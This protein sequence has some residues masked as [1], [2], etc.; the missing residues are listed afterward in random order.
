MTFNILSPD[1][2]WMLFLAVIIGIAIGYFLR[3]YLEMHK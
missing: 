3:W 1:L 2:V